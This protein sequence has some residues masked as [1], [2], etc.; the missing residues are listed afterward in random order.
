[1]SDL[2]LAD[3]D[4]DY[5]LLDTDEDLDD[6]AATE[7]LADSKSLA[8][9]EDLAGTESASDVDLTV[10]DDAEYYSMQ[11]NNVEFP[12][13]MIDGIDTMEEVEFF[14]QRIC[15]DEKSLPLYCD[16][17]ANVVKIGNLELTFGTLL[18]L[19]MIFDYKIKLYKTPESFVTLDLNDPEVLI[20]FIR[21]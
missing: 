17:D 18:S 20:K 11:M 4:E 3:E 9:S 6:L 2:L 14:K 7:P 13:V 10:I 5:D 12:C 8:D 21:L 1:M 19:H 16:C 15:S